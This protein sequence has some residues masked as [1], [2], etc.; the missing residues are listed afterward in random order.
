VQ[1]KADEVLDPQATKNTSDV[2]FGPQ[3][4]E[5]PGEPDEHFDAELFESDGEGLF[6]KTVAVFVMV[7][8]ARRRV[9]VAADRTLY[10]TSEHHSLKGWLQ[11]DGSD[12]KVREIAGVVFDEKAG[13]YLA[14][15]ATDRLEWNC[16]YGELKT[17]RGVI[18]AITKSEAFGKIGWDDFSYCPAGWVS[19]LMPTL[20]TKGTFKIPDT[21]V[22][23]GQNVHSSTVIG[24]AWIARRAG[25]CKQEDF[26]EA[27]ADHVKDVLC[28]RATEHAYLKA[29]T[30][31]C[32]LLRGHGFK[33]MS[34]LGFAEDSKEAAEERTRR[35][36][37]L[38]EEYPDDRE[39]LQGLP[40]IAE[41]YAAQFTS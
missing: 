22:V 5:W 25:D 21:T 7:S 31:F 8:H 35:I 30:M 19:S 20:S 6:Y 34:Q 41:Y 15:E 12:V 13:T 38:I 39:T 26:P 27:W 1:G 29:I 10:I 33:R 32:G 14:L 28:P 40:H 17:V 3:A 18:E 11:R 4:A 9:F 16:S 36:E 2:L 23:I 37:Y 24:S